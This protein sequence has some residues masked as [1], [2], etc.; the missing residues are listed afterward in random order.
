M[1][2]LT[3]FDLISNEVIWDSSYCYYCENEIELPGDDNNEL[4]IR[5]Y[6]GGHD[7]LIFVVFHKSCY[8]NFLKVCGPLFT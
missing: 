3:L 4:L 2:K 5:V 6:R 8:D 7:H 1:E